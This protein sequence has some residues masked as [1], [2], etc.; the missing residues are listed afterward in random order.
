MVNLQAIFKHYIMANFNEI[1]RAI[2][3]NINNNGKQNITGSTLNQILIG[4]LDALDESQKEVS[5]Q[6][7][8][9]MN[10]FKEVVRT[11]IEDCAPIVINGDVTNAPDEEDLTSVS[12][13][14]KFKN[15]SALNG[16][17]Y[18]ILRKEDS[19]QTQITQQSNTI[20]E[21]RYDFN[22]GGEIIKL[23]ENCILYFCGGSLSNCT[24]TG[25]NTLIVA[26]DYQIL[27]NV[28]LNGTFKNKV[29]HSVWF[30]PDSDNSA[31]IQLN[32]ATYILAN[33]GT[34]YVDKKVYDIKFRWVIQ[35][36]NNINVVNLGVIQPIAGVV[37][38]IGTI[39]LKNVHNSCFFNLEINGNV[40]FIPVSTDVGTQSLLRIAESSNLIFNN[41][42]IHDSNESGISGNAIN[43]CVFNNLKFENIGEHGV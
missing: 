8:N 10:G 35:D 11:Q 43:N 22:G 12:G 15:R 37:P 26:S 17:G 21:I 34:L 36:K 38:M 25:N 4:T 33:G 2:N 16:M 24:I 9:E 13:L 19:V 23:K 39:D 30:S 27:K 14:L 32:N 28:T 29:S 40:K 7:H 41:T 3:V 5:N 6:V 20:Y 31:D 18:V 42:Y 1:K